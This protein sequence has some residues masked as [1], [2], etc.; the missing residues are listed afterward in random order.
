MTAPADQDDVVEREIRI[1]APPETIFPYFTDPVRMMRWKGIDNALDAR[2]GGL[3]R[4]NLNGQDI[5]RG[6][7]LEIVPYTRIVFTWGSENGT[8]PLS[9]GS[10][11][12]EVTFTSDGDSTIVRLRHSGLAS[13][14]LRKTHAVGWE[15]YLGRLVVVA[16]GRDPGP[17]LW[18]MRGPLPALPE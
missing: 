14:E 18:D 8:F 10:T 12:V 2:P 4:V 6:Q 7:Y 1:A 17:D 16:E 15:Y 9:A 3:F 5:V 13:A 11:T